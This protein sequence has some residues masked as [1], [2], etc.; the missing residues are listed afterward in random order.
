MTVKINRK[1]KTKTV[2]PK[3]IATVAGWYSWSLHNKEYYTHRF[4]AIRREV[5]VFGVNKITLCSASKKSGLK[6][7]WKKILKIL[8]SKVCS[9]LRNISFWRKKKAKLRYSETE[10]S[11][12]LEWIKKNSLL[13]YKEYFKEVFGVKILNFG[14]VFTSID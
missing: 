7:F 1:E 10:Y 2:L 4:I 6:D 3:T 11:F 5:L 12:I 13:F 14:W 9:C 8:M